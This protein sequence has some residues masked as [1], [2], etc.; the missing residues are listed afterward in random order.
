MRNGHQ[1]R[2][3][4]KIHQVQNPI[5]VRSALVSAHG[6]QEY[7]WG[8]APTI[9]RA[10]ASMLI[11]VGLL[12]FMGG[13]AYA[14]TYPLKSLAWG[15]W[16]QYSQQESNW[17]WAAAAKIMVQRV[18]GT[19]PSQ[20][21]LVQRGK[22]ITTC[23]NQ[24]GT[25]A[26]M[27]AAI[28]TSGVTTYGT[29]TGTVGWTT[30]RTRTTNSGGVLHRIEWANGNGHIAPLI[31]TRTSPSNQVY[32]TR[33]QTTAISGSWVNYSSFAAGTGGQGISI[34]TPTHYIYR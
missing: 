13:S 3:R 31:G 22:N 34:Y 17:C 2:C 10:F 25:M 21:T 7:R 23:P 15:S 4:D 26:Q 24:T 9:G 29:Y 14:A 28:Y 27:S 19:S 33:I 16:T 1:V 5:P 12:L 30:V 8:S 11:A 32:M 20:C 18:Q 6:C